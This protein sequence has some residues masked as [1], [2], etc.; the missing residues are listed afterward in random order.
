MKKCKVL[1][2][3]LT[4]VFTAGIFL[5]NAPAEAASWREL[6]EAEKQRCRDDNASAI[7]RCVNSGKNRFRC[8]LEWHTD[9]DECM[10]PGLLRRKAK[11][12]KLAEKKQKAIDKANE[13][14]EKAQDKCKDK[15]NAR[16]ERC[17][18]DDE[19]ECLADVRKKSNRCYD[20]ADKKH[21][22]KLAKAEAM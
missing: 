17:R 12:A 13:W 20:K 6:I 7:D 8:Q 19:A 4:L 9:L 14:Y 16:A 21:T 10:N 1:V 22:K 15:G 5:L 11:I 3:L 18:G 2:F